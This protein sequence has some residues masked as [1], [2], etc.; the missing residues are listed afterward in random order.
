MGALPMPGLP[1]TLRWGW[2]TA[3]P[4]APRRSP[5]LAGRGRVLTSVFALGLGLAALTGCGNDEESSGNASPP[6]APTAPTATSLTFVPRTTLMLE[7]LESR[8]VNVVAGPAGQ[9]YTVRFALLSSPDSDPN[10]ASLDRLE[11][12]TDEKGIATVTVTAP[13]GP[14]T[15]RLRA[16][17][18][19]SVH[20]E[21]AVSV[22][23]KGYGTLIV[24]PNYLGARPIDSWVSSVR[25]GESCADLSGFPP[26]DGALAAT[27]DGDEELTIS[28]IPIGPIA[29]V[30][31]RAGQFA[32]GCVTVDDLGTDETREVTIDVADRP[33]DL[34]EGHLTLDLA[35]DMTTE[36][37]TGHLEA[38]IEV[39]L[40][41]F[42]GQSSTDGELLLD[43]M[44]AQIPSV[45]QAEFAALR[46]TADFDGVVARYVGK[47][48]LRD[49]AAAWL[50][51]GATELSKTGSF[52]GELELRGSSARFELLSA[53]G[54]D[55]AS[56]GFLG[57]ST[58]TTFAD[59]GD[60]LVMGGTLRFQATRWVSALADAPASVEYPEAMTAA[61]A[62]ALAAS[63][64]DLG[65]ELATLG[66]GQIYPDCAMSCAVNLCE[67]ALVKVWTR[68]QNAGTELSRLSVA[69]TGTAHVDDEAH[70]ISLDGSWLGTLG[71]G[72][73]SA[74]GGDAAGSLPDD[75]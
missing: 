32:Y 6:P 14:S 31:V 63:C 43:E 59:P 9:S 64:E 67:S 8:A 71:D 58:W 5:N 26:A 49:A 20:D 55:A 48:G 36:E 70:P 22:S 4:L 50:S 74:I 29:A 40:A 24:R 45:N 65:A 12:V 46:A 2:P 75:P 69:V 57:T 28:S 10:D 18:D 35:I 41:A 21:L 53:G 38:A 61:E 19:D 62:L 66:D 11:A 30:G 54:V 7:P 25:L 52:Q 72:Y 34:E 42:R 44:A 13:S 47:T 39:A 27:A 73:A 37:W 60:T 16:S 56:S 17:I 23:D 3:V 51:S 33:L 15:F 1:F 68:T